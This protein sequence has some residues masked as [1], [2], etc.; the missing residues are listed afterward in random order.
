MQ[1][2]GIIPVDEQEQ[3]KFMEELRA[4]VKKRW[5]LIVRVAKKIKR[6]DVWVAL[7]L[8][9]KMYVEEVVTACI[10][11]IDAYDKEQEEKFRENQRMLKRL[12]K[13]N[14]A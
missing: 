2:R 14:V 1:Y 6:T 10:E 3:D 12:Q 4:E 13:N 5:G 7:C 11:E 9:K 8:R